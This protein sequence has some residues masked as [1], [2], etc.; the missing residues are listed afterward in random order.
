M[1]QATSFSVVATGG[2]LLI[3]L[4]L[5]LIRFCCFRCS[6]SRSSIR[7]MAAPY[8][9]SV[10]VFHSGSNEVEE[11]RNARG[12]RS[13]P[14]RPR[15]PDSFAGLSPMRQQKQAKQSESDSKL[16]IDVTL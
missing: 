10:A 11:T 2:A 12:T 14:R 8:K 4:A 9:S 5:L 6:S 1:S 3:A 16:Q 7:K 13:T 15:E